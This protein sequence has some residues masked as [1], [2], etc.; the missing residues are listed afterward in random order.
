MRK[1]FVVAA[2]MISSQLFAQE[3]DS[4]KLLDE[5]TLTATKF[6]TKT[7]Q[8]GKVVTVITRQDIE[9]AGS[10]DL[11]QVITE[12]GG[13]F[14]NGFSSNLGKEKNIYLRGARVDYTLIT[15][16]GVPVYDA[17]G[18]GSNFD[19]RNISV[20]NVERIE[21]LKGSQSTLY[22]SDAIAGVINIITKKGGTKPFVVSGVADYG[23]F[24]TFRGNLNF[25]GSQKRFDY[26]IGYSHVNSGGFSEAQRPANSN[27]VFDKDGYH[28]NSVNANFGLQA[29]KFIR[30]QPF[31]RYTNFKG[32]LDQDA[33]T[34]EKDFTNTNKNL[35]ASLHNIISVGKGQVNVQYQFI[36]TRRFYLDDSTKS[37]NGFYIYNNQAYNSHEHFAE[38]FLVYPLKDVKLTAGGDFRKSNTDYNAEQV[39][40]YGGMPSPLGKDSVKQN[41]VGLYAALNYNSGHFSIE[42]GGRFNHHSEYGSNWAFNINPSYFI[43]NTVKVFGNLSS[44]YKTPSLYQL[45]SVYGNKNLKPETSLN[46]EG[47]LQIFTKDEHGSLRAVY[48][49]RHIKDAIAFFFNP[50]TY[51]SFYINQDKQNDHGFEIEANEKFSEKLQLKAIYSY[52]TGEITTKQNGKDTSYFNLLRRPKGNFNFFVG[53]QVTKTFYVNAQVNVVGKRSD[54]YFP[55][56]TYAQQSIDLKSYALLNFY[57]EYSLLNNKLKVFADL[58]NI[59]DQHYSDIYG[60]NTAG[61]NAYGGVRFRF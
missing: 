37:R 61:F 47:G 17:S 11:A 50:V 26:N 54:V 59:L 48:F 51:Q 49:N 23:S 30:V 38:A 32:D 35:Q 18:I 43:A 42:G 56:S 39:D 5:V 10:R 4:S 55:P 9:H 21:I 12:L 40:P 3:K 27:D 29:G 60:Y 6:S 41:Q 2:M 28:Q 19:I 24:K 46:A 57:A 36:N 52:V 13:V 14:I 53:S 58:R 16:D 8:T 34:D 33:F 1:I 22:G 15:I 44:G 45:F 25:S 7:T 20:D 31:L